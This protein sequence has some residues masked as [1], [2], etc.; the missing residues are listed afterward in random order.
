MWFAPFGWIAY[1]PR[2]AAPVL[3]AAILLALRMAGPELSRLAAAAGRSLV[4]VVTIW[5][6]TTVAIWPQLGNPWAWLTGVHSLTTPFADC[7]DTVSVYEG[8]RYYNCVTTIM[9][10]TSPWVV[11]DLARSRDNGATRG[12][13]VGALA[14]T[15]LLA[16]VLTPEPALRRRRTSGLDNA[17]GPTG[18][19]EGPDAKTRPSAGSSST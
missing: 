19:Y 1:G 11:G 5:L 7:D 3:P 18:N 12:R 17:T 16:V 15:A 10:R 9:W 13:L 4:V 6:G 2:L 14:A 8:D